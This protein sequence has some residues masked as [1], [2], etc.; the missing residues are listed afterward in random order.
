M[1]NETKAERVRRA[2]EVLESTARKRASRLMLHERNLLIEELVRLSELVD[3]NAADA[4]SPDGGR[5]RGESRLCQSL[6]HALDQRRE[7]FVDRSVAHA[8]PGTGQE[9]MTFL[10]IDEAVR[11][12]RLR[13]DIERLER[14]V[15][16]VG[17]QI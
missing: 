13:I 4:D 2:R 12:E 14:A 5:P 9:A 3:P 16:A 15:A 11:H 8:V 7:A 17:C 6:A 10:D 1:L